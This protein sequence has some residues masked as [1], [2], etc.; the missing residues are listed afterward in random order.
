MFTLHLHDYDIYTGEVLDS[1]SGFIGSSHYSKT[2]VLT[3]EN[4]FEHCWPL[5][6]SYLPKN[7]TIIKIQS[8]EDHKNISTCEYIWGKMMESGL[9]RHSL[10]VNLGGGVIGDMGGFCAATFLRGI[11]FIQVPTTLLSMADASIGGKLGIDFQYV[12]NS[13][14]VFANP[15]AVFMHTPFLKTL[16]E[17]ELRSGNA[18]IIKHALIRDAGLWM[19]LRNQDALDIRGLDEILQR[20]LIV[21]KDIVELDP[22]EQNTR[23]ALNFGHTI[24]HALES[25]ALQ[26][27]KPLKHG[28]AVALGMIAECW[29]SSQVL[30]LP[31]SDLNEIAQFIKR[32]YPSFE[33]AASH[34]DSILALMRK[35]KKNRAGKINCT[36]INPVGEVHIDNYLDENLIAGALEYLSNQ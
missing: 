7:T 15:K 5:L 17:G 22:Y 31:G 13:I 27:G 24:G 34:H 1:L 10:L 6:E 32:F 30:G 18:E 28:E 3:D 12:K 8:G 16:P 2:G 20:S 29:L 35:D 19:E 14:G 11:D 26:I 4:C 25:Y 9:D 23:K 33:V 36:L 21:K